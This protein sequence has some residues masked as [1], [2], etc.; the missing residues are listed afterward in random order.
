MVI[1]GEPS[2][3]TLAFIFIFTSHLELTLWCLV[4]NQKYKPKES[5][6]R[7]WNGLKIWLGVFSENKYIHLAY[8]ILWGVWSLINLW[9]I[10]SLSFH[11]FTVG[12]VGSGLT[13]SVARGIFVPWPGIKPVPPALEG[14]FFT[15]GP[16]GKFHTLSIHLR[17]TFPMLPCLYGHSYLNPIFT[18]VQWQQCI[19]ILEMLKLKKIIH[20]EKLPIQLVLGKI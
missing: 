1:I 10:S 3:I 2:W 17:R 6:S 4:R 9:A 5:Y 16:P 7:L 20:A 12:C 19:P 14:L 13:C 15:T 18:C 8:L 11:L